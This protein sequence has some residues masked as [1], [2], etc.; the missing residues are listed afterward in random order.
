MQVLSRRM[1]PSLQSAA[2]PLHSVWHLRLLAEWSTET[3]TMISGVL[4]GIRGYTPYTNLRVFLT[5]YTHLSDHKQAGYLQ[6]LRH[7]PLHIP[8]S[9]FS[10]TPLILAYFIGKVRPTV[11]CHKLITY[12]FMLI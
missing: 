10:S 11:L 7:A 3:I 9:I 1:A 6:A 4:G 2:L 12:Y 8:T 5:A